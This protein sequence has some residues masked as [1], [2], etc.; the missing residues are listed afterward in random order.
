MLYYY[1]INF[2]YNSIF[3]GIFYFDSNK[4]GSSVDQCTCSIIWD[5]KYII[6]KSVEIRLYSLLG[7]QNVWDSC[8]SVHTL[9][10]G[11]SWSTWLDRHS[12]RAILS[13][14]SR[15]FVNRLL[16]GNTFCVVGEI[17]LGVAHY[18]TLWLEKR[19]F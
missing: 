8:G 18:Y 11:V 12:Y 16:S 9:W 17:P 10:C 3:G 2:I 7:R 14:A 5:L 1:I 6:Y 4:I 13:S 15:Q 19:D